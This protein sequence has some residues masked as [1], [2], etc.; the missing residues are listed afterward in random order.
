MSIW[1]GFTTAM[2]GAPY[3]IGVSFFAVI[4]GMIIGF[5]LAM[6][7]MSKVRIFRLI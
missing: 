6:M 2:K 3:T 1:F 5:V 7:R 4:I